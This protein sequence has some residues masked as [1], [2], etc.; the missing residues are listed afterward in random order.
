MESLPL[1]VFFPA[2]LLLA[3]F[4]VMFFTL[5]RVCVALLVLVLGPPAG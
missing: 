5:Y 2:L 3:P 1:P 4:A